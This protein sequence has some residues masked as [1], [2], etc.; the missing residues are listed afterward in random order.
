MSLMEAT[1]RP[2]S[3][4][5]GYLNPWTEAR[6]DLLKKLWAEGLS[7]SQIAKQLP[8][9]TRNSVIGKIS[10]LGLHGRVVAHKPYKPRSV[11]FVSREEKPARQ[12]QRRFARVMAQA[13]TELG[14]F[15]R[16]AT[17]CALL[18]LG[19]NECRFPL[20]EPQ[21]ASFAFCGQP[22]AYRSYCVHHTRICYQPRK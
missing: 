16:P 11:P 1:A 3:V 17:A 13:E 18:Y 4:I 19:D 15:E 14:A 20:G 8:G 12:I 5:P 6:V 22:V 9:A 7:C 2:P 21:D 10:R